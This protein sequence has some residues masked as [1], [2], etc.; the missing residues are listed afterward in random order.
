[1]TALSARFTLHLA[2]QDTVAQD[3]APQARPAFEPFLRAG[4]DRT[5][6]PMTGPALLHALKPDSLH[7]KLLAHQRVQIR[8]AHE[9]IAASG[10][11]LG[12]GQV[13]LLP[14]RLE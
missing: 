8:A 11:R 3:P 5:V 9:G 4:A 10:L 2:A 14:Q 1:M 12:L 7:F 13:Q 6:H